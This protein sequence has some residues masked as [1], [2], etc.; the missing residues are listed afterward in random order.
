MEASVTCTIT[1]C[2]WMISR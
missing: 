1:V 2:S